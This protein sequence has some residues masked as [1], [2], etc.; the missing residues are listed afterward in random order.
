MNILLT[1]AGRRTYIIDYFKSA[2]NGEGKVFASNSIET[3][4]IKQADEYV[5]TPSIY[6]DTYID[7]LIE[8]CLKNEI[9]VVISLFDIDLFVL[10][11]NKSKF[12]ENGI[13]VIVSN[14]E[15]ISICNDKWKTYNFLHSISLKQTKSFID[16]D[17]TILALETNLVTFPL[18]LKPRWGMG[19]IGI[20][21]VD[22]KDELKVLYNKLKKE[23]FNTYLKYESIYNENQCIIIQSMIKG[24]EYGLDVLNDLEGNYVT[25]IAK[26]KLAMRAGE[27]DV[28]Q[29]VDNSPFISVAKSLSANLKHIGNLDVDCFVCDNGDIIVLELNCRFGGQYP[30]SHIAGV[31]FPK[32]IIE[33]VKGNK[34]DKKLITPTIGIKSCKDLVPVIMQ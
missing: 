8:Y 32:Q 5:I 13:K 1:S 2:L 14:E 31:D 20:Y 30:F 33:W 11:I 18:I 12:E 16:I 27:T 24:K 26:Q 10:S 4:S 7:F 3:Y 21:K 28:A 22:N 25:T 15:V 19:S 29:I 6:D 23:I 34:T 17:E 9:K